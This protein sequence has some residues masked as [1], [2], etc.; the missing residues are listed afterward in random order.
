[1]S[2]MA[3]GRH[4]LCDGQGSDGQ[5]CD[6]TT[7]LVVAL[8]P[9]LSA[10]SHGPIAVGRWLCVTDQENRQHFCPRCAGQYLSAL[11]DTR[12]L[13]PDKLSS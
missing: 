6:T 12:D 10:R 2:L 8:R 5:G 11:S 1:M 3:D 4:I 7:P 13:Q 9:M